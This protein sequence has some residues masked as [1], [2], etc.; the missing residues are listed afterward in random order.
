M[1]EEHKK[2]LFAS[3]VQDLRSICPKAG[4]VFVCP[5]CF[6]VFTEDAL[7]GCG[8]NNGH[9]WNKEFVRRHC[10]TS[11]RAIHQQILLCHRCNSRSGGRGERIL[12]DFEDFR[13]TKAAGQFYRAKVQ[14][15]PSSGLHEPA[16]FESLPVKEVTKDGA[17]LEFPKRKDTGHPL[18]SP[19]ER[20]KLEQY[21][22]AGPCNV[23]LEETYPATEKWQQAQSVLLTSA[24]LL[25]FYSFGYR[26]AFQANLDPVREY[27]LDSFEG[28]VDARLNL[29][30]TKTVAVSMCTQH[31]N[32]D[33]ELDF[34]PADANSPHYLEISFLDYHARLP[35]K[36]AFSIPRELLPLPHNVRAITYQAGEHRV[37]SGPCHVDSLIGEPDY[38]VEGRRLIRLGS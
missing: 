28:N 30:A 35:Y 32:E 5:I 24:Y 10:A 26:Y 3:H 25:A 9:V 13:R 31:F 18:Y 36:H 33:P 14:V 22:I 12:L 17:I 15:A 16:V 4:T 1:S 29:Q 37:H 7:L 23:I 6:S 11:V 2:E 27:I 21:K 38:C 8:L 34:F 19:K 20:Q